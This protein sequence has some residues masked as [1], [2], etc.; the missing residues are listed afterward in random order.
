[1]VMYAETFAFRGVILRHLQ[2]PKN[3]KRVQPIAQNVS[4][5]EVDFDFD[6]RLFSVFVPARVKSNSEDDTIAAYKVIKKMR[7][8]SEHRNM[9]P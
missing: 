6:W 5:S 8:R 2:S 3:E 4:S 9:F 1:M 7:K